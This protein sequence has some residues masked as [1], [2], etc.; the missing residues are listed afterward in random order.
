MT[1]KFSL[2]W[3]DF[4]SN[5]TN[6]F[7]YFRN[8]EYLH[9]VTLV[10]DDNQQLSAQR[11]VLSMCSEY[12]QSLFVNNKHSNMMICLEGVSKQD[13]DNCLDYM[14]HGEVQVYQNDLDKFLNVAKRF[15]L[16]GLLGEDKIK[17]EFI[18]DTDKEL[19]IEESEAT[20]E[21]KVVHSTI[22]NN[23]QKQ[24]IAVPNVGSTNNDWKQE[25]NKYIEKLPDANLKCT[26]CG[27]IS[28]D[29]NKWQN[30]RQHVETH[31]DGYSYPCDHCNQTFRFTNSLRKH[32]SNKHKH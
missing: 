13:L 21:P 11:F 5:L 24:M 15:K 6:S 9:D 10:T 25:A 32:M 31:L 1:E 26:V 30:M 12:F 23:A 8:K 22:R 4:H 3:N 7:S 14:Y 16:K 2:K 17:E 20:L 29:K 27:K 28:G 19:F 18:S